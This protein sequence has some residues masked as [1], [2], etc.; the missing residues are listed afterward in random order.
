MT[1]SMDHFVRL[2]NP[3]VTNKPTSVSTSTLK[4]NESWANQLMRLSSL[5]IRSGLCTAKYFF[6]KSQRIN[7]KSLLYSRSTDITLRLGHRCLKYECIVLFHLVNPLSQEGEGG[8]CNSMLK[9]KNFLEN[10]LR[11]L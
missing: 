7:L 4:L 1:G 8:C 5:N 11:R 2:W 3:Y 10:H 6:C 9:T